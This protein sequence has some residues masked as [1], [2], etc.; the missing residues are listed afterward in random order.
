M[1]EGRGVVIVANKWD[2][3]DD[4]YKKKAIK[5]METQLEKG[6]GKTKGI[7]I[8]YVSAKTG[9]KTER[10]MDEVLRVYEKWNT[11]VS[12]G[13]LN[14]WIWAFSKVQKMPTD[15]GKM[16]KMRYLM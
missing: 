3:I 1:D 7:P 10:I 2:L 5:Y 4:K 12:T 6:L 16:L 11:R 9:Q 13:L 8:L 14:K 15:K